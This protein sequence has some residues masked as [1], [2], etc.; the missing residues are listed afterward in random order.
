MAF[1]L[2][3]STSDEQSPYKD[4]SGQ[5]TMDEYPFAVGGFSDVYRGAWNDPE[6][7]GQIIKVAI[8]IFRAVPIMEA[9]LLET[10]KRRLNRETRVWH[11]ASNSNI[12]PFFGLCYDL[13]RAPAIISPLRDNGPIHKYIDRNPREDRLKIV[14]GVARGLKYLHDSNII[15]GDIKAHNILAGDDGSPQLCDF[16]Q[17][18]LIGIAGFTAT[19]FAGSVRYLAPELLPTESNGNVIL[20]R[21]SDVFAF[22]M[23]ALEILSGKRP[24]FNMVPET[25]VIYN[26]QIG[27]RPERILYLPT[28]FTDPLWMLLVKCWDQ[29]KTQ[30][31]SM[32]SIVK[33]LELGT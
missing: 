17:S 22:S 20:T 18:K 33:S 19:T 30:R 2:P 23:V 14:I 9:E 10:F 15:H 4:L 31:P 25:A 27:N 29:D 21:E 13:G 8:K 32:R 5:V 12:L 6:K 7:P 24:F 16:G 26:V 1:S 3:P 11:R 28:T